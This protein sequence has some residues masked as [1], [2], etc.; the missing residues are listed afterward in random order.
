MGS[1]CT[2]SII[3]QFRTGLLGTYIN[4]VFILKKVIQ[5]DF[6]S[7]CK[8]HYER[9]APLFISNTM[10]VDKC[11]FGCSRFDLFLNFSLDEVINPD[12]NSFSPSILRGK[13][14]VGHSIQRR[15]QTGDIEQ[16]R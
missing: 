12:E 2:P 10:A 14:L 11:V 5:L 8:N 6:Y 4:Y 3:L 15:P 1:L 13:L 16:V 7:P 9:M